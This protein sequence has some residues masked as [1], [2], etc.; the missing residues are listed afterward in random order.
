MVEFPKDGDFVEW[1]EYRVGRENKVELF[2][3]PY[4][5]LLI[6]K[7]RELI[8]INKRL[9][10]FESH[11]FLEKLNK[12][13]EIKL[14]RIIGFKENLEHH[15]SRIGLLILLQGPYGSLFRFDFFDEDN[16]ESIYEKWVNWRNNHFNPID[17]LEICGLSIH[18]VNQFFDWICSSAISTD[19]LSHWYDLTQIIKKELKNRLQD[20]ALLAQDY[21][22][23]ARTL[24]DFLSDLK[25]EDVKYSHELM[26]NTSGKWKEFT[27]GLTLP[28]EYNNTIHQKNILDRFMIYRP[29]TIFLVYEGATEDAVIRAI[30]QTQG[31]NEKREGIVLFPAYG[32]GNIKKNLDLLARQL[33]EDGIDLFVI[34]DGEP[35]CQGIIDRLIEKGLLQDD[36][37]KIWQNDFES[38]NFGVDLV[39]EKINDFFYERNLNYSLSMSETENNIGNK[40]LMTAISDIFYQKYK[41]KFDNVVSKKVLGEKLI[42]QRVQKMKLDKEWKSELPLED[43][44]FKLFKKYPRVMG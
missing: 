5:L 3:H 8:T 38:A 12:H 39:I 35:D 29:N 7:I 11:D 19:P 6:P 1:K 28:I 18:D 2:Y 34:L 10:F 22:E 30:F 14:D 27:Y 32:K 15:N 4:Q 41:V 44:L 21:Y 43:I 42:S 25:G 20:N 36:M 23:F 13:R 40:M 16:K 26:D 24:K 31:I 9:D 37:Y 17:I 33:K